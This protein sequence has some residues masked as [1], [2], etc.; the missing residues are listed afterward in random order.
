MEQGSAE[1]LATIFSQNHSNLFPGLKGGIVKELHKSF[2]EDPAGKT[3]QPEDFVGYNYIEWPLDYNVLNKARYQNV[4]HAACIAAKINATTGLGHRSKEVAEKLDP[5][6]EN[7]W[8][9]VL[10][11]INDD[12]ET[13][14]IGYLEVV[15]DASGQIKGLH[16]QGARF[17]KVFEEKDEIGQRTGDYHFAVGEFGHS[18]FSPILVDSDST[19]FAR[20]GERDRLAAYLSMDPV[21]VSELIVFRQP[22]TVSKYYSVPEYLPAMALIEI[23]QAAQQYSYDFFQNWGSVSTMLAFLGGQVNKETWA[24]ISSGFLS[25]IKSGGAHKSLLVNIPNQ[26]LKVEKVELGKNPFTD[27]TMDFERTLAMDVC[28]AHRTPVQI[29]NVQASSKFVFNSAG[30]GR[31]IV[32]MFQAL[33]IGPRQQIFERVLE[34]TIGQEIEIA[35]ITKVKQEISGISQTMVE[36]EEPGWK[37]K[38]LRDEMEFQMTPQLGGPDRVEDRQGAAVRREDAQADSG[39]EY[40]EEA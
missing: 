2:L 4:H 24:E 14:G 21:T 5:L 39:Q 37:L 1:D 29:A 11:A 34:Q 31:E 17:V 23:I 9:D 12:F 25:T 10:V 20:F 13:F 26:D 38:R 32:D 28:S 35:P 18:L 33:V 36:E 27:K 7:G 6:T 3:N 22:N 19:R 16:H 15:R 40:S 30:A 8:H